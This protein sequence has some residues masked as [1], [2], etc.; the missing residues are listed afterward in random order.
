[1]TDAKNSLLS[2]DDLTLSAT[3]GT[4]LKQPKGGPVP[5]ASQR[6]FQPAHHQSSLGQLLQ[7]SLLTNEVFTNTAQSK[8]HLEEVKKMFQLMQQLQSDLQIADM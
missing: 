6:A 8:E 2:M 1:M 3:D 5:V 4:A 7:G